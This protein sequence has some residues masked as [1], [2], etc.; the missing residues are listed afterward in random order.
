MILILD[1]YDSFTYNLAQYA[2]EYARVRVERNDALDVAQIRRMRPQGIIISPGPGH[3]AN[4]KDFG[5]CADVVRELGAHSPILGVCLGHQGIVHA[6]GGR[7]VHARAPIHGK[8][9]P[10]RHDARGIFRGLPNPCLIT[11]YHSLVVDKGSLPRELEV[12]AQDRGEIMGIRH[13][14]QPI[15][16]IQFHPESIGTERG[17]RMIENFVRSTRRHR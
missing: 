14:S 13:R 1:N 9:S 2:G 11:R 4:P 8:T 3:P 12:T 17:K 15:E 16:G 7:V 5:V 10:I 6:L